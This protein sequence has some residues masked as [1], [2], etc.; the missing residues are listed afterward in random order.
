M[1]KSDF[2]VFQSKERKKWRKYSK[3]IFKIMQKKLKKF[4]PIDYNLYILYYF[5]LC[6]L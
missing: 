6:I 5:M 4:F 2:Q 1:W 3:K